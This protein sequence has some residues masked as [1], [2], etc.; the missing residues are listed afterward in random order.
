M[1]RSENQGGGPRRSSERWR[2]RDQEQGKKKR[3]KRS[4]AEESDESG[5]E[6]QTQVQRKDNPAHPVGSFQVAAKN[7]TSGTEV[8]S[9]HNGESVTNTNDQERWRLMEE[10][11]RSMEER[12]RGDR[13]EGGA[14]VVSGATVTA[15]PNE[16]ILKENLRKFVA[17]KVFPSWKFIFKKDKLQ[18]CVISAISKSYMTVPPGFEGNQLAD[19]YAPTVRACLDGCRANAQSTARKRYLSK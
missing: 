2:E 1:A 10:R 6:S 5:D 17:A 7:S 3:K 4:V 13:G 14:S 12:V 9:I 16:R 8:S 15:P 18:L 19:L 11:M